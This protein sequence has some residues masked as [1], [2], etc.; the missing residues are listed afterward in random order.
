MIA[1]RVHP[2]IGGHTVLDAFGSLLPLI[3]AIAVSPLAIASV[4]LLLLSPR[5]KVASAAFAAGFAIAIAVVA[6]IAYVV[7]FA[8]PHDGDDV[9]LSAPFI[10]LGLGVVSIVLALRQWRSRPAPGA[11]LDVPKWMSKLD[12]ITPA[13]AFSMGAFFGGIKPKNLLL[14]VAVGVELEAAATSAGESA[15]VL[16]VVIVL[17]SSPVLV[18]VIVSLSAGDRIAEPLGRL[19]SWMVQHNSAMVGVILLLIGVLFI[20]KA[21]GTLGA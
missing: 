19:R 13:S 20:G 14:S 10:V 3:A 4:V 9:S 18:P 17:G 6:V 7:S 5:P 2:R 11:E 21:L 1:R 16:A 8:L 15:I 12:G